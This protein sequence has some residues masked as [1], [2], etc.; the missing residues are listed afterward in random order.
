MLFTLKPNFW[1]LGRISRLAFAVIGLA[2]FGASLTFAQTKW[3]GGAGSN[4]WNSANNW[5]PNTTPTSSTDVTFDNTYVGT[6]PTSV[7]LGGNRSVNTLTFD[8]NDPLALV[9]GSGSRTLSLYGGTITQTSGSAGLHQLQ[10][11][12]LSLLAN[13]TFDIN[14]TGGFN[15]SAV[16]AQSGGTRNVTKSGSGTLTFSAANT[17]A[18]TT[19]I[20]AG[21][22]AISNASALGSGST[23]T[24]ASGGTLALSGGITVAT[25]TNLSLTGTGASGSGALRNTSGNNLWDGNITLGGNTT[26]TSVGGQL[27]LGDQ[28]TFADTLALGSNTLTFD[29]SGGDIW[30]NSIIGG[31]GGVTKTG[32]GTL[33]YYADQ[34]TYTGT[35]RHNDGTFILDTLVSASMDGINGDLIIGDNTGA[36]AS[37]HFVHGQTTSP[38]AYELIKDTSN[39]TVNTDGWWD[40]NGQYETIASLTLQGGQV[41]TAT[42]ATSYVTLGGDLTTLASS[43]TATISGNLHLGSASRTVNIANG[44]AASDL[45]ISAVVSDGG[46][47]KT[48]AGTLTLTGANTYTGATQINAGVVNIQN[49]TALGTTAAGTTVAS[50]AQLQ[51]Q[52]GITVAGESLSL[53]GSGPSSTGALQNVS[54]SNTWTGAVS[55]AADSTIQSASD[56]L[57]VSGTISGATRNLTVNGS[58]NT[59]LSGATTLN[60]LVKDGTGTLTVT[61]AQNYNLA[62]INAGT[63][64]LGASNIL[65]D[66]M[67]VDVSGSGIF[68]STGFSDT[69]SALT[70]NGT[71][72]LSSGANLTLGADSTFTGTLNLAG[73]TLNLGGH[74]IDVTSLN[75]TGNS[76]IDFT[77]TSTFDVTNLFIASGATLTILNWTQGVDF[78]SAANW[79]GGTYDVQGYAPQNQVTFNGWT[80]NDTVWQSVDSQVCVPEPSTYGLLSVAAAIV[81]YVVRRKRAR[82]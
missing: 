76:V 18:G 58:G 11:A 61:G 78:F 79:I 43:Q 4:A 80:A 63:F 74:N 24:V 69:I 48:G 35:T 21:T 68:S 40:L 37:A 36:A 73:S 77:G 55:L 47:V 9:N 13:T 27:K 57:T 17:Y 25:E 59:T 41:S 67:T 2:A 14:G 29:T 1:K 64:V 75:I 10:F 28:T 3:D 23:T 42:A 39:V 33:T 7:A 71:V 6:L 5:N 38:V 65:A 81:L 72:N 20:N 54:G 46:I 31:T 82:S 53:S 15:V 51:L 56:T 70:G 45:T 60:S 49:N 22:L 44:A 16:I 62:D 52:G 12:T 19:T 26:I 34:N 66:T 8:S 50:G 30:V 32:T